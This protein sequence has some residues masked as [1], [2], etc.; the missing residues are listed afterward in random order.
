M[1]AE[2]FFEGKPIGRHPSLDDVMADTEKR[3]PKTLAYLAEPAQSEQDIF[4]RVVRHYRKQPWQCSIGDQ[5]KLCAYRSNDGSKCFVGALISDDYYSPEM[6]GSSLP[7]LL[8]AG[9]QFPQWIMDNSDFISIL[10]NLHDIPGNWS[11]N[12][13][14]MIL[15]LFAAERGLTMPA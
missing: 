2:R 14:P 9:Y 5:G 7:S 13:M 8:D 12:R 6:E 3:F 1:K 10:Q 15:E 4:Y 11:D